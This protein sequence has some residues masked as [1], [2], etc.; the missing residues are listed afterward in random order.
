[1]ALWHA[2]LAIHNNAR[3]LPTLE[4]KER[5]LQERAWDVD[6]TGGRTFLH[7]LLS[8]ERGETGQPFDR[9]SPNLE[10]SNALVPQP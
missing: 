5:I 4:L 1:M 9:P 6:G 3:F 2:R 10:S 7:H 8:Q